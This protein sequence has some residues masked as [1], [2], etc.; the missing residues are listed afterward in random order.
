MESSDLQDRL[1]AASEDSISAVASALRLQLPLH[2]ILAPLTQQLARV[3]LMASGVALCM[4]DAAHPL[5]EATVDE[6]AP[7]YFGPFRQLMHEAGLP[8]LL[9]SVT[10]MAGGAEIGHDIRLV[11]SAAVSRLV[12][13]QTALPKDGLEIVLQHLME[14]AMH[15]ACSKHHAVTL[16]HLCQHEENR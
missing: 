11:V 6:V 5:R 15:P 10:T 1:Q 16:W 14:L 7:L 2:P 3:H 4:A 13:V 8:A 9:V 12:A